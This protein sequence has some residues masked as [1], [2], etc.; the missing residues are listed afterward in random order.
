[1]SYNFLIQAT[2]VLNV[3][4]YDDA[5]LELVT[6]FLMAADEDLLSDYNNTCTI[7]SYDSDLELYLE[8]LGTLIVVYEEREQYELCK[9]IKN[10]MSDAL[11]IINK[12]T[13]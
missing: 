2:R 1:M 9:L 11:E 8:I 6:N 5:E 13:I 12:K 3:D 7:L 4:N 10:K